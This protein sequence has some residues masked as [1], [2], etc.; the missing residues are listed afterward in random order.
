[1][2]S[3]DWSNH[4]FILPEKKVKD[5]TLLNTWM[6]SDAYNNIIGF[7]T[8]LQNSVKS[9]PISATPQNPK[10]EY[11]AFAKFFTNLEALLE[12]CPPIQQPMR[13][14]NKAFTT[15][16]NKLVTP[17]DTLLEE[18][19][20]GSKKA[21]KEEVALYLQESF[22][23]E[24]RIDYGTGHELNFA[25]FLLCLCQLQVLDAKVDSESIVRNIFYRYI[26]LMRRIQLL[27]L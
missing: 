9:K 25:I 12:E 2:E 27:Y 17:I 22:G 1:M 3:K 5:N 10:P 24:V 8:H 19:L 14:G 7:F 15:W 4:T 26:G 11:L 16:Y 20:V 6:Q 21:A 13:F 18:L 23:S